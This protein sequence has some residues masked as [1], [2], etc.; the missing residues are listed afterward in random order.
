MRSRPNNIARIR[1]TAVVLT[2]LTACGCSKPAPPISTSPK[3]SAVSARDQSAA[4]HE[5][6]ADM[7]VRRVLDGLKQQNA[8][9]VWDFL[10]PSQQQE[11]QQLVRDL[12]DRVDEPTWTRF[13]AASRRIGQ[14]LKKL[15]PPPPVDADSKSASESSSTMMP[16]L[17]MRSDSMNA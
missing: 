8:R 14:L 6:T 3:P 17:S 1:G 10:S 13:V 7:A 15:P 5:E 11:I 4:T 12:A 2:L 9:S 16:E